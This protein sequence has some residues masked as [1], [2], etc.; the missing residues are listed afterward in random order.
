[1]TSADSVRR[2]VLLR[3]A[4]AERGASLADIQRPL[5]LAGR[6]QSGH[7]GSRLAAAGLLPDVVLCSSAVRTRQTWEL[8][9]AVLGVPEV[10][11]RFEDAVY[12]AGVSDL[13]DLLRRVPDAART[14]LVVGHEPTMSQTATI[15]A[16][17]GS[18]PEAVARVRVG[19]PTAT[20]SILEIAGAWQDLERGT[21]RL[22]GVVSPEL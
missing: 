9:R 18:A 7:V 12:H 11:V 8:S 22:T 3:H 17:E 13:I 5:A 16:G 1:M 4:K 20:F 15:L 6:R 21:G 2:L 19:V 10:D 14:V